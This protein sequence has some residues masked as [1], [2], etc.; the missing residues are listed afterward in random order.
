M[1]TLTVGDPH[2]L[3]VTDYI[4]A[5]EYDLIVI[6]GDYVDSRKE[7][8]EDTIRNLQ[9][10]I[11]FKKKYPDKVILLWGN[12]DIQY[13]IPQLYNACSGFNKYAYPSYKH[14][15]LPNKNLFQVAY[16]Y[17][18]YIWSHAGITNKWIMHN[19][20]LLFNEIY[21]NMTEGDR[22]NALF[23]SYDGIEALYQVSRER[24]GNDPASGPLWCHSTELIDD[25]ISGFT[26]IVGHNRIV[27]GEKYKY[28]KPIEKENIVFCDCLENQKE[29]GMKLSFYEKEM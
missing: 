6:T 1:K 8:I 17:E 11:E 12:H 29:Q 22:L 27:D 7:S 19:S 10:T 9:K 20:K 13:F 25:A 2:G 24:Q 21:G 23:N 28:T 5:D 18:H 4:N 3:P 15:F 26:Q 14:L 16:Q